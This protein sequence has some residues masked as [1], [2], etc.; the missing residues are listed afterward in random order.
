MITHQL[1]IYNIK[2]NPIEIS[3]LVGFTETVKS[4][5]KGPEQDIAS[6]KTRPKLVG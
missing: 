1:Y 3:L 4:Y 5:V 2:G 6:Q